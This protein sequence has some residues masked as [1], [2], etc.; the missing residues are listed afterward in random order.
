ML[1]E[2]KHRCRLSLGV[3]KPS[4]RHLVPSVPM[5]S[6][7][8][9]AR[10]SLFPDSSKVCRASITR[11]FRG[12]SSR[13]SQR[14]LVGR[15]VTAKASIGLRAHKKLSRSK[16]TRQPS[17]RFAVDEASGGS[18]SVP[19]CSEDVATTT[20]PGEPSLSKEPIDPHGPVASDVFGPTFS[21]RLMFR[22]HS[23]PQRTKAN[24]PPAPLARPPSPPLPQL[25]PV[26]SVGS[27]FV[28][29]SPSPQI[30]PPPAPPSELPS[31]EHGAPLPYRLH[32]PA[33]PVVHSVAPHDSHSTASTFPR[34]IFYSH[35]KRR[36]PT[37]PP[38]PVGPRSPHR[39]A[40]GASSFKSH[41]RYGSN[42]S[43]ESLSRV[44]LMGARDLAN[45]SPSPS[46]SSGPKFQT[47]PPKFKAFTMEAA[48]WTFSSDELQ[49]IVS[50]AI[51]KSAEPSSIRL[52]TTQA[53]FTDVPAE[54]ERLT[55]LQTELKV[56]YR[57]QARKRDALHK[58]AM[59]SAETLGSNSLR[60]RLQELAE[61]TANLDK[62][63]EELYHARDQAAQLS[64]MLAIHSG[65]ALAMALRKLHVSYLRRTAEVQSL[66]DRV[67]ALEAE[68]DEAWAQAQQVARDLDD[69]NDTLQTRDSSPAA[70]RR[71]SRTSL[72]TA[73]R[74]S[75]TRVSKAGLRTSRCLR[76]SMASQT[77]SR[78]SYAS[79]AGS[80]SEAIP[81]VPPI[82]RTLSSLHRIVTSDLSSRGSAHLSELS[83]SS[84]ARA[85]A[86]AQA[87]L[88]GYLGIDDPDLR[89]PPLRR[90]SIAVS[91]SAASPGA[92]DN[93]ARRMSDSADCRTRHDRFHAFLEVES[94]ALLA[95]FHHLDA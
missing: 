26:S 40:S 69:L 42:S 56:R 33:P 48:K 80:A 79:S 7:N 95:T 29:D 9:S 46:S 78:L 60:T 53:A 72:V 44:T 38:L 57:V 11:S 16:L 25:P 34:P 81:P 5:F 49:T 67:F 17:A 83:S 62:I 91:P 27:L 45:S 64:R 8:N 94:D 59:V 14:L 37:R 89:P 66:Q 70:T 10:S 47:S 90:S 22:K 12:R 84:E 41:N 75:S 88:Y 74:V 51:K 24:I 19:E 18:S 43:V 23:K 61:I 13:A 2:Y 82:P 36:I 32:T 20:K 15:S 68:R 50:S 52:L 54:L 63:A 93:N 85:L 6:P 73:S 1:P 39:N 21:E 87:D 4:Q 86:Q 55:A 35:D 31:E 3:P 30:L 92:R 71:S 58:A 65:S 28:P 76:T 77:G